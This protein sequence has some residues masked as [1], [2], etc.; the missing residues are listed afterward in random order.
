MMGGQGAG[1]EDF[2][3]ID[4]SKQCTILEIMK[5][6]CIL[7]PLFYFPFQNEKVLNKD[8]FFGCLKA[9]SI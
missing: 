9:L 4:I 5:C 7:T 3:T 1:L 6:F 8:A 2:V